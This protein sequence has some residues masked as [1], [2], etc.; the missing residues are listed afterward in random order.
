MKYN[1]E[2]NSVNRGKLNILDFKNRPIKN[3]IIK[4]YLGYVSGN[5]L[6]SFQEIMGNGEEKVM[7]VALTP[8]MST[9]KHDEIV[10]VFHF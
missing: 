7:G 3:G 9:M 4:K 8:E 6:F 1:L 10:K 2:E 5:L